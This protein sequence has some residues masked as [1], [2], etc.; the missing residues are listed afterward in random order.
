MTMRITFNSQYQDA[1]AALEKASEALLE[2]QRRVST[3]RRINRISDDPTGAATALAERSALAG[4]DQYKRTADSVASRLA[5]VDTAL[6]GVI[7]KLTA[8]QSTTLAARGTTLSAEQ[9]D[10]LA[11]RLG[12][13]RD[14]LVDD[15]NTTLHGRYLFAGAE[16]TTKPYAVTPP[17]TTPGYLG[18]NAE[19]DADVGDGG[20]VTIAF[21]GQAITQGT[22]TQDLFQ[23]LDDLIT[24]IRAGDDAA[25]S[26]G[27]GALQRAFE[28]ATAAQSRVGNELNSIDAQK[29]R[30]QQMK[31]S[32]AERLGAIENVDMAEAIT[33]MQHADAAYRASL[34]AIGTTSRTSLMDYL[35]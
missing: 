33:E 17:A 30:L 1:A 2:S 24:A 35:K 21:D 3:G 32:G 31:L 15:M 26:V 18:S 9:R 14:G 22:D 13:I 8:A 19:V 5:V 29:L 16:V 11:Q 34:G 20:T 25:M 10:A 7:E 23:T 27:Q 6:T 28:R 4:V 12:G